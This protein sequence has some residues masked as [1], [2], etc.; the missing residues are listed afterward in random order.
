MQEALALREC[1]HRNVIRLEAIA[2]PIDS[3]PIFDDWHLLI[4][5]YAMILPHYSLGDAYH[6]F[7]EQ[8][9]FYVKPRKERNLLVALFARDILRALENVHQAG[10]IH[11]D[12]KPENILIDKDTFILCDFG[13][14][15]KQSDM[16]KRQK[17]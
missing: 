7:V 17:C 9:E 1:A 2:E 14:A 4:R 10:W 12:I 3:V 6:F 8:D 11:R 13:L 16:V 15:A 5:G